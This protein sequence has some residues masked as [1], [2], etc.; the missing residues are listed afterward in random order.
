[1]KT[2]EEKAMTCQVKTNEVGNAVK[3]EGKAKARTE[4]EKEAEKLQREID[5]KTEELQRKLKELEE[6]QTLNRHRTTFLET[7]ESLGEVE[8]KL[9]GDE[10]FETKVCKI[11]FSSCAN[12]R[13]ESICTISNTSLLLDFIGFIRGRINEK[14]SEIEN[15]L[16]N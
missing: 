6:K 15:K 12:Y 16:L 10:T 4:A 5:R 14:V 11:N 8:N 13:D 1:M 9:R 3:V 7:L 2:N